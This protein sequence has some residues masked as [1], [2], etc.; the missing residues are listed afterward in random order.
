MQNYASLFSR[1]ITK[2]T[3]LSLVAAALCGAPGL[4][5]TDPPTP[6]TGCGQTLSSPG[7]YIVTLDLNCGSFNNPEIGITISS[8]DVKVDFA[9]HSIEVFPGPGIEVIGSKVTIKNGSIV[10]DGSMGIEGT[11]DNVRIKDMHVEGHTGD[12]IR[13]SGDGYVIKGSF[14]EGF[15]T[16]IDVGSDSVIR[17]NTV[18]G[19]GGIDVDSNTK[20]SDNTVEAIDGIEASGNGNTIRG[21]VANQ[22][23]PGISLLSGATGNVVEGN[24]ATA[25]GP[26]DLFDDN[27]GAPPNCANTW[28]NN[29]FVSTG[30]AGAAYSS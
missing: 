13:L 19:L 28:R 16:A 18:T 25:G 3:L 4:A 8:N 20:V 17:N 26:E 5:Q 27:P 15:T 22:S 14:V 10:A 30:G 12:G 2:G 1:S 9:G 29:T 11:G 23:S 21:N 7:R 24:T 6:V